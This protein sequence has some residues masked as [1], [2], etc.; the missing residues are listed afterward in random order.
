MKEIKVLITE[1][2]ISKRLDELAEQIMKEYESRDLVFLCILK[3]SIFFTVELAKR[4]KNNIQFEFI[5]VSSYE[6][7]ESTGK[8]KVNKDVSSSIK[9]KNVMV[10]EDI[11]DTGRTL[12]FLKEYLLEKSPETLKI[13]TLLDKPSRRVKEIEADY[14]GFTIEN[15]FVVG[16]GL[17]D[18]QNNRNLNY[19]GY[20]EV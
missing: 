13:C 8:I 18:N 16:Y 3:G 9:G 4:I 6:N 1:E 14:V 2:Q 17:D 19:V 7:N 11:V 12:Y 5:E 15:K 10:I 20:I